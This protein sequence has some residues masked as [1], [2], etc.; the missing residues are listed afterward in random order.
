M[1]K[2]LC[3]HCRWYKFD[4]WLGNY[5][6]AC[7]VPQSKKLGLP[8]WLS[9]KAFAC[10]AG[11]LGSVPGLGRSPGEGNR[12]P[13]LYSCLGNPMDS[14]TW[15]AT[16]HGVAE[17]DMTELLNTSNNNTYTTVVC[18]FDWETI[19]ASSCFLYFLVILIGNYFLC[20]YYI[21]QDG[22]GAKDTKLNKAIL[23]NLNFIE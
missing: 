22:L 2:T 15:R 7:C 1:V 4:P 14:G 16:V 17:S 20:M 23:N 8:R 6:L 3:P 5:N 18:I 13:L 11:D 21:L 12:N 19:L 10:N 9:G